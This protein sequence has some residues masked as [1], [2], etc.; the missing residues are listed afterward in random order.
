MESFISGSPRDGE[1][2]EEERES[3]KEGAMPRFLK[4]GKVVILLTGRYAGR[5]AVIVKNVD[6]GTG[7]RPYGH[8]LVCG[9]DR[10][11]GGEKRERKRG[12]RECVC[13]C[14]FENRGRLRGV[15]MYM[16]DMDGEE[17]CDGYDDVLYLYT[18]VLV[19]V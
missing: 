11:G 8:C 3:E 15:Y 13:V 10:C 18:C 16:K 14:V 1:E 19:C 5:K 6:D 12:E 9:V 17:V 7:S 4:P 2:R